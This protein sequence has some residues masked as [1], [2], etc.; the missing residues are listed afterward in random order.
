[1]TQVGARSAANTC[2]HMGA[3]IRVG[4]LR[5]GRAGVRSNAMPTPPMPAP[6]YAMNLL[7]PCKILALGLGALALT[8]MARADDWALSGL[9]PVE[10]RQGAEEP[11]RPEISTRWQGKMWLF[12]QERNRASF[13]ANPKTY[14]PALGGACPLSLIDGA[15]Q[16]GDP[17]LAVV[18]DG[19]VYLPATRRSRD[20]LLADPKGVITAAQAAR[21]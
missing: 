8:E 3:T 15:P 11:G 12:V 7:H 1:M 5:L 20:R 4:R 17:H 13:E 14:A 6:K 21:D 2:F 18:I 9:D 16:P 19:R 10:L